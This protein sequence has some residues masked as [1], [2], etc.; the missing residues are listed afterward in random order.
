MENTPEELPQL[1]SVLQHCCPTMSS[2]NAFLRIDKPDGFVRYKLVIREES[3]E[4]E[5]WSIKISFCPW[6]G[7]RL[8]GQQDEPSGSDKLPFKLRV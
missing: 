4:R 3:D 5:E 8:P 1:K 7:Q 6:C 2:F